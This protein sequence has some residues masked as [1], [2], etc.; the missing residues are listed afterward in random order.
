MTLPTFIAGASAASSGTATTIVAP[1]PTG[2]A[3]GDVMVVMWAAMA[4][5]GNT[6]SMPAGWVDLYSTLGTVGSARYH[7]WAKKYV[8]ATDSSADRTVTMTGSARYLQVATG[9]I[10]GVDTFTSVSDA[11]VG[12]GKA[13]SD[14]P[15]SSTVNRAFSITTTA[16]DTFVFVASFERTSGLNGTAPTLSAG[17]ADLYVPEVDGTNQ[18]GTFMMTHVDM[19]SAGASGDIDVTYPTSNASNGWAVQIGFAGTIP[20]NPAKPYKVSEMMADFAAGNMVYW[21]HRGGSLNRP[22]FTMAAYDFAIDHGYRCLEISVWKTSDGVFVGSHDNDRAINT[23]GSGNITASTSAAVLADVVDTVGGVSGQTTMRLEDLLDTYGQ[24]HVLILEDKQNVNVPALITLVNS[25]IADATEHVVFKFTV[26]AGSGSAPGQ[27]TA[28]GFKTWAYGYDADWTTY[29][30]YE[31][32]FDILGENREASSG[33]WAVVTAFGKPV[34]AHLIDTTTHVSTVVGYGADGLQTRDL[35]AIVAP[36]VV[37]GYAAADTPAVSV[38][39]PTVSWS[40]TATEPVFSG[41]VTVDT[42][43]VTVAAPTVS[44]VGTASVPVFAGSV[45]GVSPAVTVAVP[46]TAWSGTS[47]VP[48]SPGALTADTPAVTVAVPTTSWSGAV[49]APGAFIAAIAADIPTVTVAVPTVAWAG[50]YIASYVATLESVTPAVTVEVPTSV[51][52]GSAVVPV[53]AGAVVADAPTV[54]L[55]NPSTVW[56]GSVTGPI[57]T[58][59]LNAVIPLIS[60]LVPLW[61]QSEGDP[62]PFPDV[63]T[64]VLTG[65]SR[66]LALTGPVRTLEWS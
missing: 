10:R 60:I 37:L 46:T 28:A 49:S 30:A 12:V 65:P 56:T 14:T 53:F 51:W 48:V 5:S 58:G 31:P 52:S 23:N 41:S 6:Q 19:T 44:W 3:D 26:L 15:S 38:A 22:W 24:T 11:V 1:K 29:A 63:G 7:L 42:P 47:T 13:R 61:V 18:L 54:L 36:V 39:V 40:G 64:L 43:P 17:S 50:S 27:A 55:G 21:A 16:P 66:T 45:A 2:I 33:E 32:Q 57:Y 34:V 25:R 4:P 9:I 20:S 35:V 8:N 59:T 62:V